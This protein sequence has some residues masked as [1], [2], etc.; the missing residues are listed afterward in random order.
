LFST[1]A[2]IGRQSLLVVETGKNGGAD[3]GGD[4]QPG[5]ERSR[6]SRLRQS[7]EPTRRRRYGPGGPW[8]GGR[9]REEAE[10]ALTQALAV[11]FGRWRAG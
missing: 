2:F 9:R 1:I 7:A 6:R 4:H 8:H 10:D 3:Q 11:G 5:K